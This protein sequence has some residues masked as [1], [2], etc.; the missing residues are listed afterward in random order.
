MGQN[1]I[2]NFQMLFWIFD[3][4]HQIGI[5]EI[6]QLTLNKHGFQ[7]Q[8]FIK[9]DVLKTFAEFAW[10]CNSDKK[11]LQCKC[12]PEN[13]SKFLRI[14]T[15]NKFAYLC[16]ISIKAWGIKLSFHLQINTNVFY[17]MV[18][19]LWEHLARQAQSTKNNHKQ[20]LCNISRKTWRM[21]L[22][23]ACLQ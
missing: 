14:T 12:L 10:I 9:I 16:N 1:F 6:V 20:Y 23:F 2:Q 22:I 11:R 7:K 8:L 15:Q 18:V 5:R 21:K 13:F 17:K 19:S 4:G 3:W